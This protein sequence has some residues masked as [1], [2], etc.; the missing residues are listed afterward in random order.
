[1]G[2]R[3]KPEVNYDIENKNAEDEIMRETNKCS[4]DIEYS[5]RNIAISDQHDE[6]GEDE[7][8]E[9]R[10]LIL[11]NSDRMAGNMTL[12]SR[13]VLVPTNGI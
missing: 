2:L 4:Q 10:N 12:R 5:E 3:F 11:D 13:S 1:M 7:D 9:S 6:D 8:D